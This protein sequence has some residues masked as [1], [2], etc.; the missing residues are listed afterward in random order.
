M[1]TDNSSALFAT[2]VYL[3]AAN[4]HPFRGTAR[5]HS[6]K[7]ARP[8]HFQIKPNSAHPSTGAAL[9]SISPALADIF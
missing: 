8:S 6:P 7:Q 5:S 3:V 1:L 4:P 9:I 2:G